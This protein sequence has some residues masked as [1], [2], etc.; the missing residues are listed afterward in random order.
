V[1]EFDFYVGGIEDG[2]IGVLTEVYKAPAGYLKDIGSY[3][4]E[5]DEDT[6]RKFIDQLAPR[7]AGTRR[8]TRTCRS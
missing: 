6:L 8:G 4:G 3:G 7:G 2:I 5:L 1:P